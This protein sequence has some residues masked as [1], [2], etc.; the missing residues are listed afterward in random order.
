MPDTIVLIHGLWVTPRSWEEWI[1]HYEAKGYRVLAPAYPGLE[2][3]VDALRDDPSPINDLTVEGV[4][5]HYDRIVREL[6]EP[7][8]LIGHS[9]GGMIVQ[10]LLDRGLGAAGVAIDSVPPEG[11]P[12]VPFSQ[13]R[14]LFPILRNPSNRNKPVGFTPA[15]FRYAFTNT[16][17]D[18]AAARAYTRYAIPAPGSFVFIAATSNLKPGRAP[19]HVDF[20][21]HD[22]AP[23]L[24]IGGGQDHIMPASVTRSTFKHYRKSKAVTDIREYDDRSHWIIGEPGWEE[25]ADG[26]LDWAMAHA[27]ERARAT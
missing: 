9:N 27:G 16:L 7:P 2:V 10:V 13:I 18:E 14:S 25:I 22:R 21:N 23:L 26:A 8:I 12:V 5:D 3:E 24:L 15:Q 19:H 17:D 11:V 4:I 1:A 6:D 20:E